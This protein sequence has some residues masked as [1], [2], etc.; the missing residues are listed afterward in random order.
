MDT[1]AQVCNSWIMLFY[2]A[3]KLLISVRK[4][5]EINS[6]GYGTL[7]L[8]QSTTSFSQLTLSSPSLVSSIMF[9]SL[10]RIQE[11]ATLYFMVFCD[12]NIEPFDD[13]DDLPSVCVKQ[14]LEIK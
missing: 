5:Q 10:P 4:C 11:L 12:C 2:L 8:L 3:F 13:N 6:M 7:P 14:L 9:Q 1:V